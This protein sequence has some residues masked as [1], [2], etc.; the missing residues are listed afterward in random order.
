M[1]KIVAT[2][3]VADVATWLGFHDERA[4]SIEQLGGTNVTDFVAQD[5]S[6]NIAITAD[7]ED[8]AA[9]VATLAD[10]PADFG[11]VMQKHGVQ[12][13]VIVYVQG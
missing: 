7:V 2:H 13:P 1:P 11:Q 3:A 10:P 6:A 5:G 8:V 12:P 9:L 4:R